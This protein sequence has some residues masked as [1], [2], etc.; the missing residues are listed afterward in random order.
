[1]SAAENGRRHEAVVEL[2]AEVR[3]LV[4]HIVRTDAPV[5]ALDEARKAA[6]AANAAIAGS[7]RQTAPPIAGDP[8]TGGQ[9]FNPVA[10]AGNPAAPLLVSEE[11]AD[12]SVRGEVTLTAAHEGPPGVVHGGVVAMVLD[13]ILGH[14]VAAAG[15]PAM[16]AELTVRFRKPTPF[17][18]PLALTGR[19]RSRE[20]RKV[21]AE[22]EC[23]TADGT[24]TA[25]GTGLFLPPRGG[26]QALNGYVGG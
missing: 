4:E 9:P 13:Q 18:H 2:A 23:R 15:R 26:Y 24:L 5:E 14:A 20:G 22:A 3:Q 12:H 7:L 19:V 21:R 16:T 25:Q 10:G 11:N 1:V 8:H 6:A 17:N